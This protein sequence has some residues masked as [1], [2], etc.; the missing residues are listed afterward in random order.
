[1]TIECERAPEHDKPGLPAWREIATGRVFYFDGAGRPE[2]NI[3]I[4]MGKRRVG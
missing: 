2:V 3:P 4:V 1:M